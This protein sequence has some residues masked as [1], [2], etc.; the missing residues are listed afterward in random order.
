MSIPFDPTTLFYA[1]VEYLGPTKQIYDSVN[2]KPER[3][4][5]YGDHF[6]PCAG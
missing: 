6:K 3:D 2:L 4:R 1:V 5:Q